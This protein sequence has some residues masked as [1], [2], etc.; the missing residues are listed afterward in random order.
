MTTLLQVSDTHFGTERREVVEAVVALARRERPELVVLSGDITQ[1]AR[2]A[3]FARA[4]AFADRLGAPVLA[5]PGNHDIPL[6]DLLARVF[7]PY[8]RYRAAF[9][10]DLEPLHASAALLVLGVDTTRPW[11]HRHG[12]VS[13][14]QVER[15]ATRLSQASAAQLRVVVVHQPLAVASVREEL[16]RLRGHALAARRWATAGADLVLGGHIHLPYTVLLDGGTRP[17]RV[18]HAGT[19]VSSRTRQGVPNSLNIV[20]WDPHAG[21]AACCV[22][23]WDFSHEAGVFVRSE[24]ARFSPHRSAHDLR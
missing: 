23:R 24:S 17:L 9:G 13:A 11:R 3:Q 22:E 12:E 18:V 8:A 15:V 1:R 6:F 20:R 5:I 7:R 4:R 16:H 14:V 2:A 10:K 21:P 19:A